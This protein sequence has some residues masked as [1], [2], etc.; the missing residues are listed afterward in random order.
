MTEQADDEV[1]L[2]GQ[3]KLIP[4]IRLYMSQSLVRKSVGVWAKLSYEF[5]TVCVPIG[6]FVV[7]LGV[8]VPEITLELAL[9]EIS[10]LS[11]W[12]TWSVT[13]TGIV[14]CFTFAA[15]STGD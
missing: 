8:L 3:S 1:H 5:A 12:A 15:V 4:I 7:I 6:I 13:V 2:E 14:W 9:F 11:V 10:V